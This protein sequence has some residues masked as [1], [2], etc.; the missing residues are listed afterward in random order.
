MIYEST[1]EDIYFLPLQRYIPSSKDQDP[2]FLFHKRG[3]KKAKDLELTEEK[4]STRNFMGDHQ[5]PTP[6]GKERNSK[7][8]QSSNSS[9]TSDSQ[10]E[11]FH[12]M[13]QQQYVLDRESKMKRLD[14]ETMARVEYIQFKTQNE[15]LRTLAI[16]TDGMDPMNAAI[17]EE[18]KKEI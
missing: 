3:R 17:I 14:R 16:N 12:E 7:I 18:A 13:M 15:D 9:A 1:F 6:P 8:Q 4:K 11:M 5:I 10:Q 2:A